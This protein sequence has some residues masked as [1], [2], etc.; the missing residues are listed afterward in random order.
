MYDDPRGFAMTDKPVRNMPQCARKKPRTP[1]ETALIVGGRIHN[2]LLKHVMADA[3]TEPAPVEEGKKPPKSPLMTDSQVHAA[4]GL[5]KKY[6]PDLK[7]VTVSG[8]DDKPVV[9]EIVRT[10]VDVA[11]PQDSTADAAGVPAATGAE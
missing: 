3:F 4:L 11:A 1:R 2:R 7:S 8:D 6:M 5:L 10:I 9:V